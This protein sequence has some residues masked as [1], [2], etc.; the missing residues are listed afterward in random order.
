MLSDNNMRSA[1]DEALDEPFL[2][3]T[4]KRR[5]RLALRFG[6]RALLLLVLAASL[7]LAWLD[8]KHRRDRQAITEIAQEGGH[9]SY[10]YYP[11]SNWRSSP[12]LRRMLDGTFLGAGVTWGVHG[13]SYYPATRVTDAGLRN[14]RRFPETKVI[15]LGEADITDA[16]LAHLV[17]LREVQILY[18]QETNISD[19]GLR[20]L[21]ALTTLQLLDLSNTGITDRGL[22]QLR[23][24]R[25][26]QDLRLD[27]TNVTDAGLAHLC[28][29]RNL[30]ALCLNNT[31]ITDA[32]LVHL[33]SLFGLQYVSLTG[34]RVTSAG[35]EQ[36]RRSALPNFRQVD[37][38]APNV[39]PVRP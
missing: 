31:D 27:N 18:L 30:R 16:G 33:G 35:V 22:E 7:P 9:V 13:I 14:V 5:P 29:L 17:H 21:R 38:Q 25:N 39:G 15:W 10:D 26:L 11:A 4:N 8:T 6:L 23:P 24:L 2:R 34:T 1:F 36:L 3:A 32:G 12:D 19:S 37:I 20:Q 28:L